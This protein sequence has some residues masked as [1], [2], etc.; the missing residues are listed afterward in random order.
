[1]EY[2]AR[3]KPDRKKRILT[4]S[5]KKAVHP[6]EETARADAKPKRELH[7]KK[8]RRKKCSLVHILCMP[9]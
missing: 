7:N 4:H 8:K 6:S 5:G 9:R 1:V 2:E 3:K